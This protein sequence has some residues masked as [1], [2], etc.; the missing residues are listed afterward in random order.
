MF[1]LDVSI[2]SK[3]VSHSIRH[4]LEEIPA[5]IQGRLVGSGFYGIYKIDLQIE[6]QFE[7]EARGAKS[8]LEKEMRRLGYDYEIAIY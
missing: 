1:L 2:T 3:D 5:Q 8:F 4:L 7:D 6:Y